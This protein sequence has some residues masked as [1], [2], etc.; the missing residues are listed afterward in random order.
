MPAA[1][2]SFAP[3]KRTESSRSAGMPSSSEPEVSRWF[4]VANGVASG[5]D[6]M[7]VG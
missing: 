2:V 1:C 5:E 4:T 6:C 7:V 3:A